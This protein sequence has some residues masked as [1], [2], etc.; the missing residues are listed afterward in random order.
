[1]NYLSRE[2]AVYRIPSFTYLYQQIHIRK[3]NC[4][5]VDAAYM[6]FLVN[7]NDDLPNTEKVFYKIKSDFPKWR[8]IVGKK[9]SKE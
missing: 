5:L 6:T 8:G 3:T 1:M 9:P 2:R 7:S 4:K